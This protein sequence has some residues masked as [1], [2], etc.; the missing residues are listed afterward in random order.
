M[1][2][3]GGSAYQNEKELLNQ[4]ANGGQ[5][6]FAVLFHTYYPQLNFHLQQITKD[7]NLADEIAQEVFV[8]LWMIRES[9]RDINN[10]KAYIWTMARHR[11]YRQLTNIA[12]EKLNQAGYGQWNA[13]Q[14]TYNEPINNNEFLDNLD[15]AIENLPPQQRQVFLL[16]RKEKLSHQ[17][18]A[19]RM[20][21]S[22]NTVKKYIQRAIITITAFMRSRFPYL[23]PIIPLLSNLV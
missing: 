20:G 14:Q 13:N 9:V 3:N 12:R 17:E 7:E 18:I 4:I 5:S 19:T 11:A 8:K 15:Q 22:L 23:I 10:I 16:S 1:S 2:D 6:A 21:I